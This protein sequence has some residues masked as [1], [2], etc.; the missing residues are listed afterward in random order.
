MKANELRIR[1]LVTINNRLLPETEGQIYK[2]SGLQSRYD[3]DFPDS[4]GVISL[5]HTKSIKTYSQFD[6]FI[7]PVPLT[8]EWLLKFGFIR[9][10]INGYIFELGE[11][12]NGAFSIY[13][14]DLKETHDSCGFALG[15]NC[16][17]ENTKT[18]FWT[19]NNQ[20]YIY[21]HQ[22]Q[23]LFF[24]LTGKELEIK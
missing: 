23:N 15:I 14:M 22:L 1:N 9:E 12:S 20:E 16:D 11:N 2:V 7:Q 8:E 3:I 4:S 13:A 6:E 18:C 17:Y 24:A 21:V 5:D 19:T 10:D